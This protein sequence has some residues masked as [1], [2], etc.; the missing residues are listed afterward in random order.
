MK[1]RAFQSLPREE[2]VR[3]MS[4]AGLV[5][6]P[7]FKRKWV[8]PQTFEAIMALIE[9]DRKIYQDYVNKLEKP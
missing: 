5:P 9:A 8:K 4:R 3:H 6:V 2:Q 1:F 7:A